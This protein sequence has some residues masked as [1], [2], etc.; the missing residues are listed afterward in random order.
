MTDPAEV[1][2][3]GRTGFHCGQNSAGANE[4]NAQESEGIGTIV[5]NDPADQAGKDDDGIIKRRDS[6]RAR[7]AIREDDEQ[8]AS[9]LAQSDAQQ[10]EPLRR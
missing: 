5:E 2:V 6:A 1:A 3:S 4:Q 9:G 10:E 8:L 7:V